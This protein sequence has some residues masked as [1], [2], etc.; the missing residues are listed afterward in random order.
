MVITPQPSPDRP[1]RAVSV[2]AASRS[3]TFHD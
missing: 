3:I 1:F 2:E